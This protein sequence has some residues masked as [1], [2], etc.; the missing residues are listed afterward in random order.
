MTLQERRIEFIKD[1]IA[2]DK[3]GTWEDY[4]LKYDLKDSK[5]ASDFFRYY[6]R[7]GMISP[8]YTGPIVED[9]ESDYYAGVEG[10]NI[11]EGFKIKKAWGAPGNMQMSLEKIG[12]DLEED[13][14]D[15]IIETLK[16]YSPKIPKIT[17]INQDANTCL[18]LSIPD[19]H[20]SKGPIED[21][22]KNFFSAISDLLRRTDTRSLEKIIFPIGNDLI[23]SDGHTR[24]TTKG[25]AQ[26]DSADWD[27]TFD[28]ALKVMV[29]SISWLA[30]IC[31]VEVINVRGNH[32]N[33]TEFYL[34]R[35]IEGYMHN[36]ENVTINNAIES[37]KYSKYGVTGFMFEHGELKSNEYPLLFAT[38][39]PKL[40]ADT[41][42]RE[43]FLG[44]LHQQ[45]TTEIK[46]FLNRIL[47][48]LCPAD[49][50]H[51]NKGYVGNIRSAQALV[52]DKER[53]FMQMLEYRMD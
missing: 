53:G 50:W 12:G 33:T 39:K 31:P 45:R 18:V 21:T 17:D 42:Y 36:N 6:Q 43:A 23:N 19:L 52:Y 8:D 34:A 10:F 13:R 22:T 47:P 51:K 9:K 40:W 1:L 4:A 14:E 46:G 5:Q 11:P 29:D 7:T 15:K 16:N 28:A 48:S 49:S 26:F 35:A 32:A 24:A 41:K 37:R 30:T 2:N 3:Q 27:V 38:E 20:F 25:T 44:H